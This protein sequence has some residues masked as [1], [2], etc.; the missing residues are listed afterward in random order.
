V[1]SAVNQEKTSQE[2][3]D[4]GHGVFTM[5]LLL[6]LRGEAAVDGEVWLLGF[7]DFVS[8]LVKKMTSDAQVPE[9]KADGTA[10]YVIARPQ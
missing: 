8:R 1:F 9:I 7:A 10:N 2:R 5:A 6:G 4:L 3:K